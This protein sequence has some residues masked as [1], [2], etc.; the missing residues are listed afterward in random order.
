MLVICGGISSN[1][2]KFKL[3]TNDH[4]EGEG[5]TSMYT[6]GQKLGKKNNMHSK[7]Q[8]NQYSSSNK[9]HCHQL[10]IWIWVWLE[11]AMLEKPNFIMG[12]TSDR[13]HNA[14]LNQTDQHQWTPDLIWAFANKIHC[15]QIKSSFRCEIAPPLITQTLF[16]FPRLPMTSL[17]WAINFILP[18]FSLMGEN[19]EN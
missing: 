11:A 5:D 15:M 7:C 12:M 9:C 16:K 4:W 1:L 14:R 17:H 19:N 8:M 2:I 10:K 18:S 6:K 3:V 13:W